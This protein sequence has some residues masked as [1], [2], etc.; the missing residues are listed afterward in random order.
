MSRI[1]GWWSALTPRGSG[2]V[3]CCKVPRFGT[4]GSV[5]DVGDILPTRRYGINTPGFYGGLVFDQL[6]G[7]APLGHKYS[8]IK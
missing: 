5:K 6:E 7:I 1:L 8:C 3:E 4:S 2:D